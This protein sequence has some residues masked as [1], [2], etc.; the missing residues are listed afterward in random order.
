VAIVFISHKLTEVMV[1]S[2]RVT[3]MRRG[4][5]IQTFDTCT[6]SAAALAEATVGQSVDLSVIKGACCAGAVRLEINDA[7]ARDDRGTLKL[8]GLSLA[9]K[10]GEIH[11][12]AGVDGNGQQTLVEAL[13]GL[14]TLETGRITLD[15]QDITTLGTA[16]RIAAGIEHIPENR[17][18]EGLVLDLDIT[19][20]L[21]LDVFENPPFAKNG[22]RQPKAM[23]ERAEALVQEFDIRTPNCSVEV[24]KLSGGNQQK[25]I[26]ARSLWRKPTVLIAMQPTRGLD[27]GAASFIHRQIVEARDGGCAV[28][29][30]SSELDE[31]LAL[32]DVISVIYEGRIAENRPA[33]E[34][35]LIRI[36]YLMAGGK[37]S[38][39]PSPVAPGSSLV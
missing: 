6:S 2:D 26:L 37:P 12:L 36:G 18:T 32:S 35:S 7:S 9:L 20:N 3:V 24:G 17:H 21:L 30:I 15:G 11:G 14:R 33:A 25:V 22:W 34:T 27:V 31:I 29:I 19:D 4:Q 13:M 28:L 39:A 23:K 10:G 38:E 16:E 5:V 8:N 1:I